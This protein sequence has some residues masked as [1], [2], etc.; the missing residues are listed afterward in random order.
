MSN[1][2][3]FTFWI[4]ESEMTDL[5]KEKYPKYKTTQGYLKTIS[6]KEGWSNMWGNLN[7]EDKKEF[8]S[9]PNFDSAI[10]EEIT[11]IKV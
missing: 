11:G 3:N 8:I 9:L 10:F 2:L 1:Y 4:N 6:Q 7:D 5:E